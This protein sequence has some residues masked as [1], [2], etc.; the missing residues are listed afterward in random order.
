MTL[1]WNT[2]DVDYANGMTHLESGL[3]ITFGLYDTATQEHKNSF[4]FLKHLHQ[5][6]H[7]APDGSYC[8][9]QLKWDDTIL[10]LQFASQN[11]QLVCVIELPQ[12]SETHHLTLTVDSKNDDI[13]THELLC[14]HHDEMLNETTQ[15]F[16]ESRL[17]VSVSL[18]EAIPLDEAEAFLVSQKQAYAVQHFHTGGALE[19]AGEGMYRSAIW[20]MIHVDGIGK[21]INS[22]RDWGM[23]GHRPFGN[24][25]LFGWDNGFN[26][27]IAALEDWDLARSNVVSLLNNLPENGIIPNLISENGSSIDRSG[28]PVNAYNV[29]KMYAMSGLSAETRAI[30][31]LEQTYPILK[32]AFDWWL[33]NRDGNNDG[34]LE[35]GTDPLEMEREQTWDAF[36]LKGAMFESG[37][38]NSPMWDDTVFNTNTHT[39]ELNAVGLSSLHVLDA[40]ALAIIAR[41]IGQ[42][43]DIAYFEER[44]ET[45]SASINDHLW[46]DNAGIYKNQHWDGALSDHL[47]PT[48][49]YPMIAGIAPAERAQRMVDEHLLNPA[50]FW[51]DYILPSIA[52]DDVGYIDM[53]YWRGSVWAPMNYLVYE[54]LRAY[55]MSETAAALAEKSLALF[56]NEWQTNSG[57]YENYNSLTGNGKNGGWSYPVY[58]WGALL[59]YIAVQQVVNADALDGTWQFGCSY[60]KSASVHNLHLSEGLLSVETNSEGGIRATLNNE[61]LI[62]ATTM[63]Q[64]YQRSTTHI[65]FTVPAACTVDIGSL[66]ENAVI[67]I[68]LGDTPPQFLQTDEAGHI[69]LKFDT[70]AHVK[71]ELI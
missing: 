51:G 6:G 48:C 9:L 24:Y 3:R 47:S 5:L 42:D 23:A 35:W 66:P 26:A 44:I 2:W 18:T 53:T 15:H 31:L 27:L 60:Q 58:T 4:L 29:L 21:A 67:N 30:T 64:H 19:D 49:F 69:H 10:D 41:I 37:L 14:A 17:V 7:H 46:D 34:L 8:H 20:N 54:G 68:T 50:K 13:P 45:M 28:P 33:P 61:L 25:V 59:G 43:D 22:P 1:G 62:A 70:Q 52:R 63:V 39:M 55:A 65:T 71:V 11:D 36:T 56:L 32:R 57:I 38:D 12:Q 40:K 16:S